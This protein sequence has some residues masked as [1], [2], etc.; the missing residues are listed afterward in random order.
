MRDPHEVIVHHRGKIV[1]GYSVG[2]DDDEIPQG[3][4]GEAHLAANKIGE[5]DGPRRDPKTPRRRPPR[6]CPPPP[7]LFAEVPAFSQVTGGQLPGKEAETLR[8]QLLVGTVTGIDKSGGGEPS[9][10]RL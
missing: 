5:G 7:L 2:A 9:R 6:R 1:G 8:L 4:T 10:Y 3:L